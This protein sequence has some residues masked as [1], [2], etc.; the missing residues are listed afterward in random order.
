M[1]IVPSVADIFLTLPEVTTI[2]PPHLRSSGTKWTVREEATDHAAILL[3][4]AESPEAGDRESARAWSF[5]QLEE[6]LTQNTI[7]LK[8]INAGGDHSPLFYAP[9]T[10]IRFDIQEQNKNIPFNP[11]FLQK[12]EIF[13]VGEGISSPCWERIHKK[14]D[15]PFWLAAYW[16][17]L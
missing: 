10:D 11:L 9:K 1:T 4:G 13:L 15:L 6:I 5:H 12:N 8:W 16:R 3:R 17:F 14:S 2:A 7:F